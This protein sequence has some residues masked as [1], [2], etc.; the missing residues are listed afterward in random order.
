MRI[1]AV[2]YLN[3]KPLV[4]TLAD[5]A[6][7]AE[8]VYDV[9]SR[10]AD[11]LAAGRLDV[12]LVPSIELFRDPAYTVVSDACIGCSGPVLSVKLFCRTPAAEI[13]SL[14]L[15]EGSLTSV[16]LVRILLK[17]RFDLA[18]QLAPLPIGAT[19]DDTDADAVLLIGDRAIQS[20]DDRFAEVWDLG[21]QWVRWSGLP[22]VFAMWIGRRGSDLATL[23]GILA[24]ARDAGVANLAEIAGREA[25]SVGMTVPQCLS[26]LSDNLHF[27]FG[28][29]EQQ[30]LELF[31]KNAVA[32]GL[33]PAGWDLSPDDCK[34]AG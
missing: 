27:F 18:P 1:G 4:Y 6:P 11:G 10:L 24:A 34:T 3:S 9:P 17:E 23:G 22:F 13:R 29:R 12:A 26:Y 15:D 16:A 7:G 21:E 14:A 20:A 31:Y 8:I 19:V 2:N 33:A 28:P 30:G 5:L 32:L 25:A